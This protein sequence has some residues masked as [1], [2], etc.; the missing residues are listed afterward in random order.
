MT[1][2]L[3]VNQYPEKNEAIYVG[4]IN[5]D[6][7]IYFYSHYSLLFQRFS[8]T[9]NTLKRI[10][11]T[12]RKRHPKLSHLIKS[13]LLYSGWQEEYVLHAKISCQQFLLDAR[14]AI[15][16]SRINLETNVIRGSQFD[17][18]KHLFTF[19]LWK[20]EYN[21]FSIQ[22]KPHEHLAKVKKKEKQF[23]KLFK[24]VDLHQF[25]YQK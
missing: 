5:T 18:L 7:F 25:I 3:F 13:G 8:Y 2:F 21:F 19:L 15:H 11:N 4:Y 24:S 12:G 22:N 6:G 1:Q 16:F 23:Q 10:Y 17:V 14:T 20:L 9:Y